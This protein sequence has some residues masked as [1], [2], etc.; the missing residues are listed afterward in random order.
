MDERTGFAIRLRVS[1]KAPDKASVMHHLDDLFSI[2][3]KT[4]AST[5]LRRIFV[6]Y[7]GSFQTWGWRVKENHKDH[8]LYESRACSD[9]THPQMFK[10]LLK[11]LG[12]SLL[13]DDGDI[14]LRYLTPYSVRE[15]V[16]FYSS[17]HL[18]DDTAEP[19]LQTTGFEY[20]VHPQI[21]MVSDPRHPHQFYYPDR[22][23]LAK[24]HVGVVSRRSRDA[25]CDPFIPS[26]N[27]HDL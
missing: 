1:K 21:G 18:A 14:V 23:M 26:W 13:L 24:L 2:K 5:G 22:E 3:G 8:W 12:P 19:F 6:G 10:Q 15:T 20:D 17:K 7:D 9:R 27:I 25:Q 4:N 11:K 16:L